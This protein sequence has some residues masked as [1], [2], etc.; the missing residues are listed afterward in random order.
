MENIRTYHTNQGEGEISNP[1]TLIGHCWPPTLIYYDVDEQGDK[2]N[3]CGIYITP[4]CND[5]D[6]FACLK[7][8]EPGSVGE[9]SLQFEV[10]E[11]AINNEG[12]CQPAT[13]PHCAHY[14]KGIWK[15][16]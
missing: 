2:L 15:T 9:I 5:N 14:A 13:F 3:T 10:D 12:T 6:T 11:V 4:K 1:S 7:N 16:T 8:V